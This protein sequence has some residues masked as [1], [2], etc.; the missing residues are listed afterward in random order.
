MIVFQAFFLTK[1]MCTEKCFLTVTVENCQLAWIPKTN[2]YLRFSLARAPYFRVSEDSFWDAMDFEAGGGAGL[3]K[4]VYICL[5]RISVGAMNVNTKTSHCIYSA[6]IE[7]K[8][9]CYRDTLHKSPIQE[10]KRNVWLFHLIS[11]THRKYTAISS[12]QWWRSHFVL[13]YKSIVV[14]RIVNRGVIHGCVAVRFWVAS[15]GAF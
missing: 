13:V 11:C 3:P 9:Q 12:N 4:N 8:K 2:P 14:D 6:R 10:L 7:E 5:K 1:I 15:M